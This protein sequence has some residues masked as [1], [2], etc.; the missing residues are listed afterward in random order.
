MAYLC[1]ITA[2]VDIM[3][4]RN[5]FAD[6]DTWLELAKRFYI[7]LPI[8]KTEPT[9][10][11]M[12]K[13]LRRFKVTERDYLMATGYTQLSDFRRLNPDWPLRAFVG[14]LLEYVAERDDAKG[15]LRAYDRA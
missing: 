1:A 9:D 5:N 4:L 7:R 12:Q 11:A 14:V 15:V 3:N 8:W 6:E 13:W 10:S 2:I